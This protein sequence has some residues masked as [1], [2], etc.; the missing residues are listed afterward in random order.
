[1]VVRVIIALSI[2]MTNGNVKMF[3]IGGGN[4]FRGEAGYIYTRDGADPPGSP[5]M[6][7]RALSSGD[8]GRLKCPI[9]SIVRHDNK[10]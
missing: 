8:G 3:R 5:R 4:F 10:P 9:I 2:T 6:R 7:T 1:M